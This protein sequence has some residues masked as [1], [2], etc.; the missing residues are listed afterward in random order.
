MRTLSFVLLLVM[1]ICGVSGAEPEAPFEFARKVQAAY[2]AGDTDRL[3]VLARDTT[4]DPWLVEQ[5][6][7]RLERLAR[8]AAGEEPGR[9]G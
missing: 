9:V 6:A 4:Q 7:E 3:S 1:V 8:L 2:E 5:E